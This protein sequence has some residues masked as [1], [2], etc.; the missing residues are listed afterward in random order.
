MQPH[1]AIKKKFRSLRCFSLLFFV[2]LWPGLLVLLVRYLFDLQLHMSQCLTTNLYLWAPT[3]PRRDTAFWLM[4]HSSCT[5]LCARSPGVIKWTT[6]VGTF[7]AVPGPDLTVPIPA[8]S[9]EF[10]RLPEQS[11]DFLHKVPTSCAKS[12]W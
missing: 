12:R 1:A 9:P 2:L 5:L 10:L 6:V 3:N 11:P 8:Q 4:C 7:V